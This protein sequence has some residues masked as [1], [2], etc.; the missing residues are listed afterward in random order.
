V[1]VFRWAACSAPSNQSD[2][3]DL[4]LPASGIDQ[5][6]MN[7]KKAIAM[8][9]RMHTGTRSEAGHTLL[10]MLAAVSILGIVIVYIAGIAGDS[11]AS[12][13]RKD[14]A[15]NALNSRQIC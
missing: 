7:T 11:I 5:K 4:L 10:E 13:G 15:E 3:R 8:P 6:A 9:N 1:V 2:P 12:E 14:D